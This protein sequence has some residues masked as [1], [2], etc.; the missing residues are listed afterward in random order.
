VGIKRA[1]CIAATMSALSLFMGPSPSGQGY[2]Q[3]CRLDVG[4]RLR[5]LHLLSRNSLRRG[6]MPLAR[7]KSL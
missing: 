6:H 5:L 1:S 7:R 4:L 3:S 2:G